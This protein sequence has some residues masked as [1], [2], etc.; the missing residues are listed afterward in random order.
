MLFFIMRI[1]PFVRGHLNFFTHVTLLST[2]FTLLSGLLLY[3]GGVS[4]EQRDKPLYVGILVFL[5]VGVVVL[6]FINTL[7]GILKSVY[8]AV[9]IGG[10]M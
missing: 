6:P 2:I 10:M 8:E 7:F 9:G 5:N 3:M 4:Q 1:N